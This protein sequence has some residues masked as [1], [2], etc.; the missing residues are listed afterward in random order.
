MNKKTK[1]FELKNNT[2]I[3]IVGG[4]GVIIGIMLLITASILFSII[5]T[6][7]EEKN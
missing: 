7:K 5:S 3:A 6:I 2:N 4:G 1:N